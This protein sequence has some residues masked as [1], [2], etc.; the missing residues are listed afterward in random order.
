MKIEQHPRIRR[1]H[2]A[3]WLVG[4]VYQLLMVS[5]LS[6]TLRRHGRTMATFP[7]AEGGV[8]FGGVWV[9]DIFEIRSLRLIS[10]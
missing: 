9:E 6:F 2:A 3:V 10:D 4:D 8:G 1:T 7:L 5:F